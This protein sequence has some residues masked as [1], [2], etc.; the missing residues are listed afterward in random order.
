MATASR[1]QWQSRRGFVLAAVGSAVG[2]GNMWRFSY[3]T[4]EKGGAAF[5]GLYLF[6]TLIIGMPVMMAELTLGRGA[7]KGPVAALAHFGGPAWRPLGL[8]FV[9]TGFLILS[10]YG[11]IGGWTLR[12]AVETLTIGFP[13][14]PGAHFEDLASGF[15][16]L[17]TQILF[18]ALTISIV[19]GGISHGIER[20]ARIAMPALFFIVVGIALYAASLD[21]S[22]GGYRYYLNFDVQNALALDVVVAAAGQA[23]FSLSLGMGAILTFASYLPQDSKLA[24]ETVV[25]SSVANRSPAS[26]ASLSAVALTAFAS[27][28]CVPKMR[29][30]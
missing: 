15:D 26:M 17:A 28:V 24:R 21:G 16:S 7:R 9:V 19:S 4:A 29:D 8:V 13:E 3:L 30:S 23:F 18:M 22:G 1:E 5:V 14:N 2:L 6:F 10:Y 27:K 25:I 20:V 11:V 12:Y